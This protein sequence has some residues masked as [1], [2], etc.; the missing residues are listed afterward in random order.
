MS[1]SLKQLDCFEPFCDLD[2][3]G[4]LIA[5][6]QI[7]IETEKKGSQLFEVGDNDKV[8]HFLCEGEIELVAE[9]GRKKNVIAGETAAHFPIALLRPRKFSAVVASKS[10][11]FINIDIDLLHQLRKTVPVSGDA[12]ASFAHFDEDDYAPTNDMD[13]V[14][15]F[16][17]S[18]SKAI[19]ENR[20]NISN[21]DNVSS[22]IFDV[23]QNPEVS[24]D[25]IVS[26]VQL[27]AAIAAK[28][29]RDANSAFFAGLPKVDTVRTAVVRLGL[30]LS[31]QL[32]TVMVVKEVFHSDKEDLCTA[33]ARLWQSSMKLATF[34]AVIGKRAKPSFNQGQCLLA[35]LMYEMGTLVSIA[36]LD[37][38]PSMLNRVSNQV[39]SAN[40]I[41]K[42]MG[43]DLLK[44]W[45]FPEVIIEV[46]ETSDDLK[47]ES[48]KANLADVISLALVLVRMAAYRSVP[49][50]EL[51]TL[52]AYK[53]LG[54]KEESPDF[55]EKIRE[56]A[57]QYLKLFTGAFES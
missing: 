48:N 29:I 55:I 49:V 30:D 50:S 32:I 31:V 25:E 3:Q 56:E 19:V 33:M 1:V 45:E 16:L 39:L 47:R 14:K 57:H 28:L 53:R 21:F 22:M 54:F 38:Y 27:D 8:E 2:E 18:A 34:A 17:I 42:K 51:D 24:L 52:P 44:H 7:S 46:V 12:F 13:A 40:N 41:K 5:A 6:S 10:A 36:Y 23:I 4:K 11:M 15:Q 37:Q 26:A 9:D 43:S 35:G 20:I